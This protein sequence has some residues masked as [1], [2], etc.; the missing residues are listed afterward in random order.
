MW[1]NRFQC[2][3]VSS[4]ISRKLFAFLMLAVNNAGDGPLLFVLL[5]LPP[6][7]TAFFF[8]FSSFVVGIG[9]SPASFLA[10][11]SLMP[12]S[13]TSCFAFNFIRSFLP[14]FFFFFFTSFTPSS[15]SSATLIAPPP[16]DDDACNAM[17]EEKYESVLQ[18]N[19]TARCLYASILFNSMWPSRLSTRRLR[20]LALRTIP[21]LIYHHLSK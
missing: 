12:R 1:L 15:A 17:S 3:R 5:L 10:S 8:L 9:F 2:F 6:L 14:I 19:F 16:V 7:A 13:S 18:V 20:N 11:A 4:N 21:M